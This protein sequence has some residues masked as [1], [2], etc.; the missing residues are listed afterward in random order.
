MRAQAEKTYEKE[1]RGAYEQSEIHA[2]GTGNPNKPRVPEHEIPTAVL[3]TIKSVLGTND[4]IPEE[5]DLFSYGV[6]SVACMA[7]RAKLQSRIIDPGAPALPLNMVYDCG[8][9]KRHLLD[10]RTGRQTESEDEIQLMNDLV[11]QY[12]KV[13]EEAGALKQPD[14]IVGEKPSRENKHPREH[15]V[16]KPLKTLKSNSILLRSFTSS[17]LSHLARYITDHYTQLLTGA[18]GALGAHILHLLRSNPT[19]SHITCLVRATSPFAAHERVSKSLI[20]R[21]K[22][23]LAPHS[24]S[25][26]I[27]TQENKASSSTPEVNCIPTTLSHPYLGLDPSTYVHLA[28]TTTLIIHAAWA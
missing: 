1:I 7:I 17:S 26:P 16:R 27:L 4:R 15:I 5:A 12:G 13:V 22:P 2:S 24:D 21:G 11:T 25:K 23:G 9:I 19:I 18:T 20:A 8:N 3:E 10:L 14:G 6:D 28:N